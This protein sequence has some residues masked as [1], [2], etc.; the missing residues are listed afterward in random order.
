M[1]DRYGGQVRGTG[2]RDRHEGKETAMSMLQEESNTERLQQ[3][4]GEVGAL[5]HRVRDL[6]AGLAAFQSALPAVPAPAPSFVE[7]V[8]RRCNGGNP[9]GAAIC[10]W[11]GQQLP[12]SAARRSIPSE[13]VAAPRA[14]RPP[15][16]ATVPAAPLA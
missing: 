10:M 7:V 13:P 16:P 11:C 12:L 1:G 14:A 4:E 2:T 9:P 15:R 6:E 8:C 3:L 5:Q